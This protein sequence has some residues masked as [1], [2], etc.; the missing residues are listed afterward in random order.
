MI[1]LFII[2][3]WCLEEFEWLALK[4]CTIDN[5]NIAK[6]STKTREFFYFF[7]F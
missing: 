3:G 6:D 2:F 1:V 7:Y 5:F 4:E